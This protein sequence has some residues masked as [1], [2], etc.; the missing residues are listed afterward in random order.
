ML[1]ESEKVVVFVGQ[2]PLKRLVRT[3]NGGFEQGTMRDIDQHKRWLCESD[4]GGKLGFN[5]NGQFKDWIG[6]FSVE[7]DFI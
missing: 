7:N 5:K 2:L 3:N 1:F 6:S 4:K